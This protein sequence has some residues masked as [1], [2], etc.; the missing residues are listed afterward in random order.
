MHLIVGVVQIASYKACHI[1]DVNLQRKVVRKGVMSPLPGGWRPNCPEED[2]SDV[3]NIPI[4]PDI[5]KMP[6][7][8]NIPNIPPSRWQTDR[9]V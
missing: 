2:I 6:N 3:P 5:P 1:S 9:K 8:L 4:S 7:I